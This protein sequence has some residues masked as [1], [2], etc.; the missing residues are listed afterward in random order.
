M[1]LADPQ[2]WNAYSY[3]SNTPVT[4][5]DPTGLRAYAPDGSSGLPK[6]PVQE[7]LPKDRRVRSGGGVARQAPTAGQP[8]SYR[9]PPR[10]STSYSS[11]GGGGGSPSVGICTTA[12]SCGAGAAAGSISAT[13]RW[14]SQVQKDLKPPVNRVG[15]SLDSNDAFRNGP[16]QWNSYQSKIAASRGSA[17][18]GGVS[19]V[20]DISRGAGF[21]TASKVAPGV[22]LV[23]TGYASYEEGNGDWGKTAAYW[24]VDLAAVGAGAAAGAMIGSVIPGAGTLVGGL[25]GGGFFTSEVISSYGHDRINHNWGRPMREWEMW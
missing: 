6:R 11:Y 3:A 25:V 21:R 18:R 20:L 13:H 1:D 14:G 12:S 7:A 15:L 19:E 17:V 16:D 24:G 4:M 10:T 9:P 2:Q 23:M 8:G 22:G 5:S